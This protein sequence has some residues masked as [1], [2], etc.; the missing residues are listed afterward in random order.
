[1]AADADS[2][3]T[4]EFEGAVIPE[5]FG[6]GDKALVYGVTENQRWVRL[7]TLLTST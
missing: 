1:V 3:T 2:P 7:R 4:G 6:E 5:I